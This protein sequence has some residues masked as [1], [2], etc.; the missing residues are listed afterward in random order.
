[1]GGGGEGG[2]IYMMNTKTN[3]LYLIFG[4]IYSD[5]DMFS[6]LSSSPSSPPPSSSKLVL[7]TLMLLIKLHM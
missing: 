6:V 5:A 1:M 4:K 3:S 2:L 7:T